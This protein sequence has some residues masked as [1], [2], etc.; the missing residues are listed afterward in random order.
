MDTTWL[1]TYP[2]EGVVRRAFLFAENA[3]KNI[4]RASGEPYIIHPLAVA[5]FV[6]EWGLDENSIAAALLHDVIEDTSY[7][8][9]DLEKIFG[10]EIAE[11]VD[12]MTK[13]RNFKYGENPD[14]ENIRK[15]I[16]SFGKDLRVILIKLADRYHNMMTLK[17]KSPEKQKEIAWETIEIY[18]PI[19]YRLGM[20]KLSGELEDLSFPFLY[21]EEY[22]WLIENVKERHEERVL[23]AERLKSILHKILEEAHITPITIDSRAK[24][25]YS[26]YRKLMRNDM[27]LDKIYDL[28]AVRVIVNTVEECYGVLG[29]IHKHWSPLPRRFKDYIAVPKSNGYRSL[30]TVVS[31]LEN[32]IIEIQI[33]TEEMHQ[34]NEFGIAAH[35]AYEQTKKDLTQ[36][37]KGW[38]GVQNKKELLWVQQLQNWQNKFADQQDFLESLK[39]DFFK[40]RIFVLTPKNDVIDLPARSTPV[41]FAYHIHSEIGNQCTGAKVNGKIVPLDYELHSG[42]VIEVSTQKGKKP[43]EDWLR[44]IKSSM[45]KK[46]VR[47]SLRTK[48]RKLQT[49]I[50][51]P[52]E[53]QFKI[54]NIDRPGYL[55]EITNV[56]GDLDINILFLNSQTDPRNTFSTVIVKCGIV[57]KQKLTKLLMKIKKIEGTKE[58]SYHYI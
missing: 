8:Q 31:A 18:A 49:K 43:S 5:Q 42:D 55:R 1:N 11:I 15:L 22:R 44:F 28:V 30:H 39:V 32:K 2:E 4:M 20:Q 9:K 47:S 36:K 7:T 58:I 27:D 41:D 57:Q 23:Y 29:V 10:T 21:E 51:A 33:K 12:G 40:E 24:R 45:A 17:Y 52:K 13:L 19:A 34:E 48:D 25:Y 14:A 35:W 38:R 53:I 6:R 3:H 16:L 56:F 37:T 54:T 46:Y 50:S 26:L